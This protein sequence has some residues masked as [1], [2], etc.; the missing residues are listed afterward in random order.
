M[1]PPLPLDD[2]AEKAFGGR[3]EILLTD[4]TT[5]VDEIAVADA[6]PLGARPSRGSST[7]QKFRTLA[8][9]V[10]ESG[11]GRAL[12]RR[13]A[14]P[15]RAHARRA[16]GLTIVAAPG[17]LVERRRCPPGSSDFRWTAPVALVTGASSGI[18]EAQPAAHRARFTVYAGAPRVN[19]WPRSE[20]VT[21]VLALD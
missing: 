9:G 14:A 7:S 15:A 16:G 3:V 13:R 5:I 12:P 18:G 8:D 4:G 10:L 2:P 19:A 17:A 11:G 1:D 6:H 21:R 20:R